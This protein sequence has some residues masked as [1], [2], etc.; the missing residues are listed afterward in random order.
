MNF[1][2]YIA[3]EAALLILIAIAIIVAFREAAHGDAGGKSD[4]EPS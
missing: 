2:L 1:W 4:N 3:L